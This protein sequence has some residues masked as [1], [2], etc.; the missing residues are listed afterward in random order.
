MSYHDFKDWDW[1]L[2]RAR[3]DAARYGSVLDKPVA[4]LPC[5]LVLTFCTRAGSDGRNG[6]VLNVRC[7]CMAGTRNVPSARYYAYDTLGE[8]S[9]L[10]G[11]R[12]L[13]DEHLAGKQAARGTGTLP[14]GNL[15]GTSAA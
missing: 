1:L 12:R 9:S 5:E 14:A 6:K 4:A 10:P 7:R 13:W 3:Q 15:R 8:A 2:R 11:A